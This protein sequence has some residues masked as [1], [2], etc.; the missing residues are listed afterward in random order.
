MKLRNAVL[1]LAVAALSLQVCQIHANPLNGSISSPF[2]TGHNFPRF[3][4][5]KSRGFDSA[6]RD[7]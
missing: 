6:D 5:L 4:I 1:F 3:S 7:T 2:L